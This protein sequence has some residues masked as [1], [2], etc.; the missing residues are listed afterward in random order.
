MLAVMITILQAG[1][2]LA[3]KGKESRLFDWKKA[4]F[5]NFYDVN[6]LSTGD[7]W[8]VGSKGVICAFD[9]ATKQWEVQESGFSRN[10]YGVSF[11]VPEKGWVVGQS[12]TILYTENKGKVWTN[13]KSETNEHLF[14]VSFVDTRNG[15]AVGAFG[16]IL[17]TTNGGVTWDKQGDQIDRI[18]NGVFFVDELY[19]WI[20]GEF[21][22]ILSTSN[23][24]NTWT[25]QAN[26]LGEKTLFSV[27]FKDRSTGFAC[28][29]DGILLSTVDGGVTWKQMDSRMKENLFSVNGK[30]I[31]QWCVGLKGTLSANTGEGWRDITDKIPTRAW[32]KKCAFIDEKNGWIVGSVGTALRT[33]DGGET[34]VPAGKMQNK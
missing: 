11:P 12:G 6:P 31:R 10:L 8:I 20:V 4:Y 13:Q 17:H 29:M 1:I 28:G 3:E 25:E 33:E 32:L 5:F 19:G 16:T 18:Y 2:V 22:T 30:G 15:W 23:G 24:G 7:V 21:G 27:Y 26:P 9:S 14:S 34:W